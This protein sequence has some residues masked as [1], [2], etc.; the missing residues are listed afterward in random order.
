MQKKVKLIV[1]NNFIA[2]IIIAYI[3]TV[4]QGA[5]E[6]SKWQN[7]AAGVKNVFSHHFSLSCLHLE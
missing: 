3:K 2:I 5:V 7:S 6:V 1:N 4:I